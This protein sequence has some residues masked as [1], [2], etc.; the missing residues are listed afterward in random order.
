VSFVANNFCTICEAVRA[1]ARCEAE[2]IICHLD[3]LVLGCQAKY[4][5]MTPEDLPELSQG[6][7]RVLESRRLTA[8][9]EGKAAIGGG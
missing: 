9:R 7:R 4:R 1:G 8:P 5:K 3:A 6:L 2:I